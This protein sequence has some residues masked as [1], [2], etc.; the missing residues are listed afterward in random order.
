MAYCTKCGG[1]LEQGAIFCTNCGE[2]S[3]NPEVTKQ[4][5]TRSENRNFHES[6]YKNKYNR[7]KGIMIS[8]AY[9]SYWQSQFI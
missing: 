6:I 4:V 9:L 3:S 5:Q 7:M 2:R 1:N 8:I